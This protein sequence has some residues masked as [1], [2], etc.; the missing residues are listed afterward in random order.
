MYRKK[1]YVLLTH[2]P[3]QWVRNP[4]GFNDCYKDKNFRILN[5]GALDMNHST[6]RLKKANPFDHAELGK[7]KPEYRE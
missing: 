5:M 7:V 1:T 3:P 4:D 2:L 6:T